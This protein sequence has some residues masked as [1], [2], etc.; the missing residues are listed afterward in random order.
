[1][2][3]TTRSNDERAVQAAVDLAT[4]LAFSVFRVFAKQIQVKDV[5]NDGWDGDG[6]NGN[7][8]DGDAARGKL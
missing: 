8:W 1:M 3:T 4:L 7:G 6:R 2:Y 5:W